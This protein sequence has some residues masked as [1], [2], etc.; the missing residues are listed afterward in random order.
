LMDIAGASYSNDIP[1]NHPYNECIG[2]NPH[3]RTF[4]LHV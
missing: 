2:N 3:T 4:H 1:C